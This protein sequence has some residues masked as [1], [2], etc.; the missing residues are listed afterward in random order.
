MKSSTIATIQCS[1]LHRFPGGAVMLDARPGLVLRCDWL[2]ALLWHAQPSYWLVTG[3]AHREGCVVNTNNLGCYIDATLQ[4]LI[5]GHIW[6]PH[7]LVTI[8]P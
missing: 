7:P 6:I 2:V 1:I 5:L 3:P 8:R 4:I